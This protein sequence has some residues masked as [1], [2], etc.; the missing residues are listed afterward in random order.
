MPRPNKCRKVFSNPDT[1]YFKPAGIPKHDLEEI[2]LTI[3]EYEA[4]RLADY[5]G[6]YQEK[7]AAQMNVSRQTFGNIV[8]SAHK[9][10][11]DFLINGKALQI[12]GGSIE[13]GANSLFVVCRGCKR[14]FHSDENLS[15][16]CPKCKG[17]EIILDD[18]GNPIIN[19]QPNN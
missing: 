15:E 11:A 6:L 5:E 18:N 2:V 8:N 7:A 10:I 16:K 4:I 13:I 1:V 19:C 14:K 12:S 17:S 9:K 3:D